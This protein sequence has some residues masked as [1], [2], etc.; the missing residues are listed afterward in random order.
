MKTIKFNGYLLPNVGALIKGVSKEQVDEYLELLFKACGFKRSIG[1]GGRYTHYGVPIKNINESKYWYDSELTDYEINFTLLPITEAILWLKV[2]LGE[3]TKENWVV[4]I[5]AEKDHPKFEEFKKW[6]NRERNFPFS[7]N[8]RFY[9]IIDGLP[10][11]VNAEDRP[12][13]ISLDMFFTYF[14]EQAEKPKYVTGQRFKAKIQGA[15]IKGTIHSTENRLNQWHLKC[16]DGTLWSIGDGTPK[17]LEIY[18]ITDLELLPDPAEPVKGDI[19]LG[20][21]YTHQDIYSGR[22]IFKVV[23]I[24]EHDV[25]LEGDYSG[26]THSVCQR[27][28]MPIKGLN[29]LPT[30]SPEQ[31]ARQEA[32]KKA[33]EF[34]HWYDN[35]TDPV[36]RSR[37]GAVTEYILK[38][39]N[40]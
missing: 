28:W 32:E 11:S 38:E 36:Y 13:V 31:S 35:N 33:D 34:I 39:I 40:S 19:K 8:D 20:E 24:R 29:V 30:P 26:G 14:Y 10:R 23:G 3:I 27:S 5:E 9:G 4:D 16:S 18:N 12:D 22:E 15:H 17:M 21:R 2:A 7:F 25:E 1:F 6:L 37:K